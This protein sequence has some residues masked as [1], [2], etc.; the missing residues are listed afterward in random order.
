MSYERVAAGG[1]GWS[2][3]PTFVLDQEHGS[4]IGVCLGGQN[5]RQICFVD[6]DPLEQATAQRAGCTQAHR[7][8]FQTSTAT[9]CRTAHPA[10]NPGHIWCCP[11][12]APRAVPTTP[13]QRARA[14]ELIIAE[15]QARD[16]GRLPTTTPEDTSK[17]PTIEPGRTEPVSTQETYNISLEKF[18]QNPAPVLAV[19]AAVLA[20]GTGGYLAFRYF[21]RPRT[22]RSTA[23]ARAR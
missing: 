14:T 13:E 16:E 3:L 17:A 8:W 10:N 9:E 21:T 15:Q 1:L 20:L 5:K 11:E 19:V 23:L 22:R 4:S 6:N 2:E 12:N 18:Q 7:P